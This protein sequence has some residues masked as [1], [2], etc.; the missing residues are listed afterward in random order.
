MPEEFE[1][2]ISLNTAER[3]EVDDIIGILRS[4]EALLKDIE[5]NLES[6]A[7][8]KAK[9]EW[10]E[11][12]QLRFSA[13]VNGLKAEA[14]DQIVALAQEGFQRAQEASTTNTPVQWPQRFGE[15][16]K[17]SVRNI[18]QH[19]AQIESLT[20]EAT[21]RPALEIRR[22][23]VEELFEARA[24]RRVFSMVDGVLEMIGH[25]AN[26][27]K[28]GIRE[29][30]TGRYVRCILSA[31]KWRDYL[32][33]NKL[34]DQR[35]VVEGRVAY[36]DEGHPLSIIDVTGIDLRP[37]GRPL[38]DL[39]GANPDITEGLSTEEYIARIRGDD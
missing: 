21:G 27:I 12:A 33:E 35:V 2:G 32:L 24:P 7:R 37:K 16:A 38:R 13:S 9:W 39:E 10:A 30:F 20:V 3:L 8:T 22:A 29:H 4:I 25:R 15:K 11:D 1:F 34:W 17:A 6:R 26:Q 31:D 5:K 18:L 14:L 28:A 23:K 36:D 19:L